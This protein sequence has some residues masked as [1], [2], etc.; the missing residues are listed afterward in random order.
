MSFVA[1]ILLLQN[2]WLVSMGG[3]GG[4]VDKQLR[5]TQSECLVYGTS[6]GVRE[7]PDRA[8]VPITS[9]RQTPAIDKEVLK[10]VPFW[11]P[12]IQNLVG[13]EP[14]KTAKMRGFPAQIAEFI[15]MEQNR[16]DP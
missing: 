1:E 2:T 15:L 7:L 10:D 5:R 13:T 11:P 14:K 3:S 4:D 12:E 6:C 9:T 16:Y 8:P